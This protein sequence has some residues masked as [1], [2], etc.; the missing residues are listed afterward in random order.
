MPIRKPTANIAIDPNSPE[1][2]R[3]REIAEQFGFVRHYGGETADVS[4]LMRAIGTPGGEVEVAPAGLLAACAALVAYR[5]RVG[6]LNF[7][8]EKADDFINRIRAAIEDAAAPQNG[9]EGA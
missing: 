4:A 8:L 2:A 5:D 7:Q 1:M 6:P 9:K 3:L